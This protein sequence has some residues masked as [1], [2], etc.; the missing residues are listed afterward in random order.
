MLYLSQI[1]WVRVCTY[2]A[3]LLQLNF[4]LLPFWFSMDAAAVTRNNLI[5]DLTHVRCAVTLINAHMRKQSHTYCMCICASI[6]GS[7]RTK[8]LRGSA[9]MHL[10]FY[11]ERKVFLSF[12]SDCSC[13][14]SLSSFLH[15]PFLP[16][17][18]DSHVQTYFMQLDKMTYNLTK[19]KS[20]MMSINVRGRLGRIHIN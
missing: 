20:I 6:R 12:S 9:S 19:N 1:S 15:P 3:Y 17:C 7:S 18:V 5:V 14:L 11:G 13:S 4:S 2:C 10:K 16:L 8:P